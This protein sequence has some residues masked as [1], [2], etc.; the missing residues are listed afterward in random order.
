MKHQ[1]GTLLAYTMV[2]VFILSGCSKK[3]DN[4]ELSKNLPILATSQVTEIT[5]TTAVSG[6][7][8]TSEGSSIVRARGVCIRTSTEPGLHDSITFNGVGAGPF[9]S[10]VRHMKRH[11][12]YYIRAY[13]TNSSGTGY[14]NELTFITSDHGAPA[15]VVTLTPSAIFFNRVVLGGNVTGGGD[16][17]VTQRG[18]YFSSQPSPAT[19]HSTVVCGS[20]T[21]LFTCEIT[22]CAPKSRYYY[23]AFATN[24]A[25]TSTGE[26]LQVTTPCD[27]VLN[28]PGDYQ[29]WNPYDSASS[30]YSVNG[31][32]LYEGY[33]WFRGVTEFKYARHSWMEY[34][35]DNSG[36]GNLE[37]SGN[38]LKATVGG[39]YKLNV[40]LV[41]M[42]HSFLKTEWSICGTATPGGVN[43][44]TGLQYD[45]LGK[46]WTITTSLVPGL[47]KF[48]AN[49][50]WDLNYGDN[51]TD[52]TLEENG[53]E[54]TVNSAGHYSVILNLG[55]PVYTYSVM[56]K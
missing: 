53:A 3:N 1:T 43:S 21:G 23:C 11:T 52:G 37:L 14:G 49:H 5:D 18:I 16:S 38:N 31:D 54:I 33:L 29:G 44:D 26:V 8:V 45:T 19:S 6:G 2:M 48:R 17:V 42:K 20:G 39:Y 9:R 7:M 10:Y 12:R 40:N 35:G 30:I 51:G 25:G 55:K 56:R 28:V 41:T 22:G 34:W 47:F 32:D 15:A 13:A 50:T 27:P 4:T 36:D 24:A 46:V